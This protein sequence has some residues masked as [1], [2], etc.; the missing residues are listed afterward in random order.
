MTTKRSTAR[1]ASRFL[2]ANKDLV[3][4]G[5]TVAHVLLEDRLVVAVPARERRPALRN[6]P[7]TPHD[8]Q[9][10]DFAARLVVRAHNVELALANLVELPVVNRDGECISGLGVGGAS[11][12]NRDGRLLSITLIG[13]GTEGRVCVPCRERSP[14]PS[15][16]PRASPSRS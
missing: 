7:G 6:V 12:I 2:N 4:R 14:G 1:S 5:K 16:R 13:E 9:L 15:T 8:P 10:V 11:N 3:K